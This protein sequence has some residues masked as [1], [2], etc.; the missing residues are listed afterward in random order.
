M[1]LLSLK[2]FNNQQINCAFAFGAVDK[3]SHMEMITN[4]ASI[5]QDEE[6]ITMITNNA[7]KEEIMKKI[8]AY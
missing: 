2:E 7:P 5:L 6:F 4:V 8:A 1:Y 3:D